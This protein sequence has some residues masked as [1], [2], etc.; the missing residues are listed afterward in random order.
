MLK[1]L[2][3]LVLVCCLLFSFSACSSKPS[4]GYLKTALEN[5][6]NYNKPY[7]ISTAVEYNLF[8]VGYMYNEV[9]VGN[10]SYM[11]YGITEDGEISSSI[12]GSED[13]AQYLVVDYYKD[14]VFSS[15]N[16]ADGSAIRYPLSYSKYVES[17]N[18]LNVDIILENLK[19]FEKVTSSSYTDVDGNVIDID[20]YEGKV[21]GKSLVDIFGV[22]TYSLYKSVSSD[23]TVNANVRKL[24]GYYL[25]ESAPDYTYSDASVYIGITTGENPMVVNI[26]LAAGGLGTK[27]FMTKFIMDFDCSDS[28]VDYPEV[29]ETVTFESTIQETADFVAKYDSYS[30]ALVAMKHEE[31][32]KNLNENNSVESEESEVE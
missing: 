2:S 19:S 18:V 29:T 7:I 15:F 30:E 9:V 24:C 32:L 5:L 25:E 12:Y 1:K 27:V 11:Q 6:R 23:T 21:D 28:V 8:D 16:I 17:R 4:T 22:D 26:D 3:S 13:N 31:Q 14:G 10:D 20:L